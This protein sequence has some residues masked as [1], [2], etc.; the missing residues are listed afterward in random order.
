MKHQTNWNKTLDN[1]DNYPSS[2]DWTVAHSE[3][4]FDNSVQDSPGDW[5]DVIGTFEGDWSS[6]RDALVAETHPVNWAT[7]KH[8]GG[9]AKEPPMLTQ[10]EY[11]IQRAG[12]DPRG[13]TLT[14]KNTFKDWN[15]YPTLKAMMDYFGLEVD[16]VSGAK[17]Q[18]HIQLTGQMFNMHIDKLWDRCYEDPE[19]VAR[20][21]IMLDDWQP[22]HFYIYGNCVYSHW[23]AGEVHIFDWANVPHATSNASN[24]SRAVLQI[25]GLKTDRTREILATANKDSVFK[26]A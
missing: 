4:H 10:E 18:A 24:T 11:D 26:L 8:Y 23:R 12:G 20:I 13:L 17:R 7:R 5:F 6:E 21:T 14:N 19:R 25:T 1:P 3:Y 9:L 2:W 16:G 15:K 22:G